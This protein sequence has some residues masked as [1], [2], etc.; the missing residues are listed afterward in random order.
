MPLIKAIT[1]HTKSMAALQSYLEGPLGNERYVAQDFYNIERENGAER[2]TWG[3]QMEITREVCGND[4]V[5]NGRK[6]VTFKHYV[7]SPDPRD[8]CRLETLR[9]LVADWVHEN[10]RDYE[11][12]VTYHNDNKNRILHAHVVVNNTN[13]ETGRRISGELTN[14]R[15][16]GINN[17]LQN[18]A[19]VHGLSAF[20]DDHR[21]MNEAEMSA[22]GKNVSRMGD[23]LSFRAWRNHVRDEAPRGPRLPRPQRVGGP[24][25]DLSER[26]IEGRGKTSWVGEV[27]DAVDVARRISRSEREF[28]AALDAM[29]V[30]V[31]E[32][33]GGDWVFHH[34]DGGARAVRG[35]R[36]GVGYARQALEVEL[37]L[38]VVTGDAPG[39][40]RTLPQRRA[41][42]VAICL[43]RAA[44]RGPT[45]KQVV[46]LLDYANRRGVRAYE[47]FPDN[48]T[49][50]CMLQLAREIHLYDT[51][52]PMVPTP[53]AAVT[54]RV[55]AGASAR[56]GQ[57][58]R[59][60]PG[61][62]RSGERGGDG[63]LR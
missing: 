41:V 4:T 25:K 22:A 21:S 10:F 44:G 43:R 18:L 13:L 45:A 29:G 40:R 8:S 33:K 47:D 58:V 32:S 27:R 39:A 63:R 30:G 12:V 56:S 54:R 61:E 31:S 52:A 9:D 16:R 46:Y 15:V 53:A 57:Q 62:A 37:T 24:R 14:A 36:L 26:G 28:V 60:M 49:G 6:P 17:S 48:K 51:P 50:R 34:P 11:V 23:E 35:R 19:L 2:L 5:A 3:R 20:S 1:G 55:L 38:G 59:Q 7:I 42:I